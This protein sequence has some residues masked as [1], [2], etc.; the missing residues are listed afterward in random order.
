MLRQGEKLRTKQMGFE[1]GDQSDENADDI[2]NEYDQDDID[3]ENNLRSKLGKGVM[4]M[5]FMKKA[6]AR[7]EK[8][9]KELEMLRKLENGEGDL[10][11]FEE[12]N[13][14]VN[15]TK[16]QGRRIYTPAAASQINDNTNEQALED[17]ENDNAKSLDK[18]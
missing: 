10:E 6:E 4:N 17:I 5:D 15:V 9:L 16:N 7:K 11:I 12:D 18:N 14:A 2:I 8:N 1:D 3:D 13:S